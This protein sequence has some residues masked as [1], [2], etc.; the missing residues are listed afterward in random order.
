MEKQVKEF[1]FT[2]K[3]I[4][5]GIDCHLKSWNV[6]ILTQNSVQKTFHQVPKVEKLMSY[7]KRH[8]PGGNYVVAYE[9]GF[10]GFWMHEGFK[11]QGVECVVAHPADIPTT[12]KERR[13][14]TDK[15]DSKK[16]GMG[17]RSG[18]LESIYIPTNQEQ[19]DR[20]LVRQR[21]RINKDK[22]R[23]MNRIRSHLHF[24][25]ESIPDRFKKHC[26]SRRFI[27]W[28]EELIVQRSDFS[29]SLELEELKLLRALELK[30]LRALQAL[31]RSAR[32]KPTVELLTS[33]PGIGVLTAMLLITEI[34]KIERFKRLDKLCSYVGLIP[35][36]SSSGESE[37]VGRMTK[38]ANKRLKTAILEAAWIAIRRD[39]VLTAAFEAWCEKTGQKNKAIVK[40]ARKLLS[41]IM[42]VWKEGEKYEFNN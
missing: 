18:N 5:A 28:L 3:T 42:S 31:S 24:Y 8:Y 32:H 7:L 25:G 34:G 33:V 9:A 30:A 16:I 40:V 36:T 23:V 37:R 4:Y 15:R 2:G 27:Q 19:R 12:D 41:R 22:R 13:Q 6:T 20:S 14:K 1:D 10:S 21:Y 26:W 39:T 11:A 38:R 35:N 29:L 17:L